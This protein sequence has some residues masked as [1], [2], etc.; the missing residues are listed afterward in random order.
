MNTA[1]LILVGI[2]GICWTIVYIELIRN[3]F[4]DKACG[5]PLFALGLNIVWGFCIPLTV[6]SS[7]GNLYRYRMLRIWFGLFAM[8][9]FWCAGFDTGSNTFLIT[10]RSTLSR[11]PYSHWSCASVCSWRS[12]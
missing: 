6:F 12:I 1:G 7:R 2:S 9:R 5:M 4:R 11:I 3:G 10:Q 8:W